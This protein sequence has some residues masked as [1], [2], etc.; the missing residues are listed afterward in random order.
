LVLYTDGVT[1]ARHDG[2]MLGEQRLVEFVRALGSIPTRET[3]QA[4]FDQ[5]LEF[6]GGGLSDDVAIVSV[7]RSER[8]GSE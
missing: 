7:S 4:L 6:T 8:P 2:V 5:V 3:P 1:E